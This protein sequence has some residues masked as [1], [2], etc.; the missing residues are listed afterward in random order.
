MQ[1]AIWFTIHDKQIIYMWVNQSRLFEVEKYDKASVEDDCVSWK[2]DVIIWRDFIEFYF[3]K[4][5]HLLCSVGM[6]DDVL[7][8]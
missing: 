4:M 1:R 6:I 3:K 2:R 5:L 7:G 8:E